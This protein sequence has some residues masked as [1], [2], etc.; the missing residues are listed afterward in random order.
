MA[1]GGVRN[2]GGEGASQS[3]PPGSGPFIPATTTDLTKA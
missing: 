2:Y 3:G 1:G